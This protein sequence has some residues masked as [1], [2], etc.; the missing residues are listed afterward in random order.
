ME[1]DDELVKGFLYAL[2]FGWHFCNCHAVDDHNNV[3]H[4]LPICKE[5][6]IT[7]R[8]ECRVFSFLN[9][10]TEVN[11]YLTIRY[12]LDC[13]EMST[14]LNFHRKLDWHLIL[15]PD[16]EDGVTEWHEIALEAVSSLCTAPH[17]AHTYSNCCWIC[18]ASQCYQQY[19]CSWPSW[20][21]CIRTYF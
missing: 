3:Q 9:A 15:N 11:A 5:T 12:A 1:D 6:W 18:D 7:Q 2:P 17:N 20:N 19:T 10:I 4:W 16:N 14:L 21:N 8:W 13:A